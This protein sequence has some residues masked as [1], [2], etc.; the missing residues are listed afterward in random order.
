MKSTSRIT[1][2]GLPPCPTGPLWEVDWERISATYDWIEALKGVPQDPVY[3]A[4]GD[5]WTHTRMVCEAMVALPQWR[6][7]SA[8]TRSALFAAAL[9]HD[10]A[11][12]RCTLMEGDRVRSPHHAARGALMAREI[13]W[14]M[15][16]PPALR[17]RV[18]ALVRCHMKPFWLINQARPEADAALISLRARCD[19]L[20]ILAQ[21]DALGRISPD[22]DKLLEQVALFVAV[23]E[24][25]GCLRGPRSFA[26][27]HTR[28]QYFRQQGRDPD[29]LAYDDTRLEVTVMSGLPGVGKD[30][31]IQEHCR[32]MA[33]VSLD[34]LRAQ[35][36]VSPSRPQGAVIHAAKDLAR[37]RLRAA[38]PFVW[39]A[40]NLT[41]QLRSQLIDLLSQYKASVRLVHIEAT[42]KALAR[43][44][45]ARESVVPPAVID[46]M[47]R[48][49]EVPDLSEAHEVLWFDGQGP[50]EGR[51]G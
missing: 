17:E 48:K 6:A 5:V 45:R 12:P 35:M 30:R 16:A 40:T 11:K 37:E 2:P 44:N 15:G 13:L 26:S 28:F 14:R 36:G 39:N 21:A 43:Q 46:R 1:T 8:E 20:A 34:A 29:L 47:V 23:C 33:V 41:R 18:A 9:L 50:V 7:Q 10:V 51:F 19:H 22:Q 3:H 31:W 38:E 24:E 4:E 32:G 27:P 49:W 42:A 25:Q